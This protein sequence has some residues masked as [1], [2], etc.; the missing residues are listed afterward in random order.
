M[1]SSHRGIRTVATA[2]LVTAL[3]AGAVQAS[4]APAESGQDSRRG[5]AAAPGPAGPETRPVPAPGTSEGWQQGDLR[6]SPN[7]N[8][9]V[10]RFLDRARTA[11]KDI[12]PRVRAAAVM[13]GAELKGFDHRL[14]SPDSLKRKVATWMKEDPGLTVNNALSG[15][16]D[17]VR[18]TLVWPTGEY[19]SGVTRASG[20]LSAWGDD[21]VR[22]ANTWSRDRGYKAVNAAWR[23]PGGHV[24]EVQFH[25]PESKQAQETTHKL[26][27]EQRLPSTP[28][29][30]REELQAQQGEIFAAVPVPAGAVDLRAPA[31]RQP[32]EPQPVPQSA[33]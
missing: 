12:S 19:T 4:A 28:P 17:S 21:S 5:T 7:D 13:S 25:T 9:T 14:K 27:E 10:D 16:N 3:S 8:R 30:R 15:I 32:A 22:W 29:E 11:E 23:E 1:N 6:L 24:Y 2:A 31:P 20:L 26:Y 18:Y 33:S